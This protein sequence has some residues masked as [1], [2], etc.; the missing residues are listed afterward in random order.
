MLRERSLGDFEGK[1]IVDVKKDQ[2]YIK[3]FNDSNFTEFRHSFHQKAPFG[4]NYL[5]V[6]KRIQIFLIR[7]F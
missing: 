3:F 2:R 7:F 6:Y 5:D 1:R 4:G